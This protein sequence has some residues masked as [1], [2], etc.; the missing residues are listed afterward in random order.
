VPL[1][2]L[3]TAAAAAAVGSLLGSGP[4]TADPVRVSYANVN[5]NFAPTFAAEDKG[6]FKEEGLEV[7]LINAPGGTATP[8]LMAGSLTYSAS[9]SSAM[10]AIL[11]GAPLKVVFVGTSRALY[12]LWS[13]DPEVTSFAQMKGKSVPIAQRGGTEELAMRVYLKAKGLPPDYLTMIPL[14]T[15]PARLAAIVGGTQKFAMLTSGEK[16]SFKEA[17]LLDKGRMILDFSKEIET[18]NGGLVTATKTVTENRDQVK[19]VLRA[20]WKGTLYMQAEKQGMADILQKRLSTAARDHLLS[21]LD[22]AI[23]DV[24]TDGEME[25][26]AAAKEL[27]VRAEL[28]GVP[29]DKIPPPAQVYDFS[30]IRE[31]IKELAAE[32]WRPTK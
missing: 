5:A 20:L 10:S 16:G 15:G 28:L 25:M 6:Y 29:P 22:A 9:T 17:G 24:D 26:A 13:F 19:K 14:G 3:T 31:V 2:Y 32:S 18:Q 27:A 1:T 11:K 4:A 8:A 30:I 12:Q 21:G 7:E 23:E